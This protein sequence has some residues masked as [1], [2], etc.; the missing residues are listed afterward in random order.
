[1]FINES[2]SA[3][4]S[5][6]KRSDMLIE[7]II[8]QIEY[9]TENRN[10]IDNSMKRRRPVMRKVAAVPYKSKKVVMTE[11]KLI[12]DLEKMLTESKSPAY[13]RNLG[14][15]TA[16][17]RRLLESK[18][19]IRKQVLNEY[20]KYKMLTEMAKAGDTISSVY[21]YLTPALP[22][23]VVPA[24][25]AYAV[26]NNKFGLSA[27]DL[28]MQQNAFINPNSRTA[29]GGKKYYSRIQL[30]EK[31]MW[32]NGY[33]TCHLDPGVI[34]LAFEDE[35]A[36]DEIENGIFGKRANEMVNKAVT[37]YKGQYSVEAIKNALQKKVKK[38][39]DAFE[40]YPNKIPV[41]RM[42]YDKAKELGISFSGLNPTIPAKGKADTNIDGEEASN[43]KRDL[44]SKNIRV[45]NDY[46]YDLF[47]FNELK[48][49][50]IPEWAI[51]LHDNASK[52]YEIY[53]MDDL[54]ENPGFIKFEN[55]YAIKDMQSRPARSIGNALKRLKDG[56]SRGFRDSMGDTLGKIIEATST[57]C[58]FTPKQKQQALKSGK[59]ILE[60]TIGDVDNA[61][62]LL[63]GDGG[64][65]LSIR[66]TLK[67]QSEHIIKMVKYCAD[68]YAGQIEYIN[69][70][71]EDPASQNVINL[72]KHLI[73]ALLNYRNK[74][75]SYLQAAGKDTSITAQETQILRDLISSFDDKS[76]IS[77]DRSLI[78][79]VKT[80][81][82]RDAAN[83]NSSA[84][85]GN[86]NEPMKFSDGSSITE[87]PATQESDDDAVAT[88]VQNRQ[89]NAI[90]TR[91]ANSPLDALKNA[92]T[93]N[94][95]ISA[96]ANLLPY[97]FE[98]N[99]YTSNR[100]E[101]NR[102]KSINPRI[103]DAIDRGIERNAEVKKVEPDEIKN[104]PN[105]IKQLTRLGVLRVMGDFLK[106]YFVDKNAR[107]GFS[108]YVL[109]ETSDG[110]KLKNVIEKAKKRY[111]E[112]DKAWTEIADDYIKNVYL[113]VADDFV[114]KAFAQ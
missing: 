79:F 27:E 74:L 98:H 71:A 110:A 87:D 86:V 89:K 41:L 100:A 59:E 78:E 16:K 43:R 75:N 85:T 40:Q 72:F 35:D 28:V 24:I 57:N 48:D 11:A 67:T 76:G 77:S 60:E 109:E 101:S 65:I 102:N 50:G 112:S 18:K 61:S 26:K 51:S 70:T 7:S 56:K 88:I 5:P 114:K 90:A 103:T 83:T 33:K 42:Y 46:G 69:S 58:S 113:K 21:N 2:Y 81:T 63:M 91:Q 25:H 19:K 37:H 96:C 10:R 39:K 52:K 12:S 31:F 34:E 108:S 32:P 30:S 54:K 94:G 36:L 44:D 64:K 20:H 62:S 93:E 73:A 105:N 106:A 3:Y 4:D 95:L 45:N 29:I 8:N 15:C 17:K 82:S 23:E 104:N 84:D 111:R 13:Y 6:D 14:K 107:S 99:A 97:I 92:E 80:R 68:T 9:G 1:M 55:E 22:K 47:S 38:V 66:T 53:E 49:L